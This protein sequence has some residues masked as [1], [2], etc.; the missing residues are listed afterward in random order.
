MRA[1]TPGDSYDDWEKGAPAIP[2][3]KGKKESKRKSR[4]SRRK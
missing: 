3:R 1:T 2:K 4:K